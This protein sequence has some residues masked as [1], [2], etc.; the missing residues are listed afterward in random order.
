MIEK[1]KRLDYLE[2]GYDLSDIRSADLLDDLTCWSARFGNVLLDNI[3]LQ[4]NIKVLD[5]ACA[6]GFPLIELAHMFGP[7]CQFVGVDLWVQALY[8]AEAKRQL[9]GLDYVTVMA[10]NGEQLP[11][12]D[13]SFDMVVSNLGINNFEHLDWVLN[14]INRVLKVDGKLIVTTNLNGHMKELYQVL[15]EIIAQFNNQNYLE[16][17]SVNEH[18]RGTSAGFSEILNKQGF[19]V[20]KVIKDHFQ[21]RYLDGSALLRHSLTRVGFLGSWRAIVDT[22]D[23][24][25]L[26]TQLETRLNDLAAK[27]GIL[28]MTV[29]RLYLEAV[30]I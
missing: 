8:R 4:A 3:P 18:H 26:F 15:H 16:R 5:L 24:E 17:L 23:E 6:L 25:S 7:S 27:D 21:M 12:I 1:M 14:E 20:T 13:A 11:F 9:H 10:A 30:K 22:Q 19:K 2:K 28:V 29:P